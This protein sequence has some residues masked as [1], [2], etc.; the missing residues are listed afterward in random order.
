MG[1]HP[2]YPTIRNF[3][4]SYADCL[5]CDRLLAD[6]RGGEPAGQGGRNRGRFLEGLEAFVRLFQHTS[7]SLGPTS[8]PWEKYTTDTGSHLA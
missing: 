3:K 8:H 4:Q 5:S 1:Y 2:P 7:A 6:L